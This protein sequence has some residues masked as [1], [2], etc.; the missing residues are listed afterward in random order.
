MRI[1]RKQLSKDDVEYGVAIAKVLFV[2]M[3]VV[4]IVQLALS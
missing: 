1:K 4:A 3:S 2:F